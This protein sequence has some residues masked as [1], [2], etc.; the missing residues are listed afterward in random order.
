MSPAATSTWSF[1]VRS[2]PDGRVESR[3][4]L[5]DGGLEDLDAA[6]AQELAAALLAAV[7]RPNGL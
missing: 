2:D 5:T 4:S 7:D 1:W 6:A 3:I